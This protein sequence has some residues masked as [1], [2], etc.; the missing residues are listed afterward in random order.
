[1]KSLVSMCTVAALTFGVATTAVAEEKVLLKLPVWFGTHL[2]GLGSSP[3]FFA[4]TVNTA[5]GGSVKVKIYE[6]N[7][8]IATKEMLESVSNGTVNAGWGTPGYNTGLLG[9]KAAIF[10]AVP[11][12]PEAP[13]FMAWVYYGGGRDLWQKLY[14][15][16]GYNVHSI[17]CS[18]IAPETSGWFKKPINSVED[19]QGLRMRFFGLGANVMEKLGVSTSLLAA[20][21][22][23]P[24]LEKGAIDATE[25]S[26]PAIDK[27]LGFPKLLKHNYYP[28]WHQPSTMFDIIINGDTWAG[29]SASQQS[30]V[31]TACKA[32]MLDGMALGEAI[33]F[34]YM[35]AN[36][37]ESG[38]TNHY[39]SDE[40]LATFEEKWLEV[41]DEL[42]AEDPEFGEIYGALNEFRANYKYW[43]EWIYLPRPSKQGS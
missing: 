42:T 23:M 37:E 25:F 21:D 12:G 20:G 2:T 34:D 30:V 39:W 32:T 1:M 31:E 43:Q 10:S 7:K 6:P 15:D 17:P 3:L 33:Q 14:D 22:I 35:I 19:L 5:S 26:M 16:A 40:M 38:V 18:I 8:L 11:F 13:E 36:V 9:K 41:V 27:L 28:G 4:E 29:M 24:A